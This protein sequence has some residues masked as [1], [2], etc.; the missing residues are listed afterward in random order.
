MTCYQFLENCDFLVF[1]QNLVLFD[2]FQNCSKIRFEHNRCELCYSFA[3]N[4]KIFT[5]DDV[6]KLIQSAFQ[7]VFSTGFKYINKTDRLVRSC[8]DC[9]VMFVDVREK[10]SVISPIGPFFCSD[11][12]SC[13]IIR[14]LFAI[15][16]YL[17]GHVPIDV[18]LDFIIFSEKKF[19][20]K[21]RNF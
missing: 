17:N 2:Q 21:I 4:L 11:I 9:S 8:S 16:F 18:V 15:C 6:T 19:S 14:F 5:A 3:K 20:S 7:T 1:A 10:S 13:L 12:F